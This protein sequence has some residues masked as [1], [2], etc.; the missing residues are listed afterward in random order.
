MPGAVEHVHL[1]G[2]GVRRDPVEQRSA[3]L[4]LGCAVV[5]AANG[6]EALAR[7]EEEQ[8]D[9]VFSD[10]VMPG[11]SGVELAREVRV[12]YPGL[13][14]V[15]ASGYSNEMLKGAALEFKL[16]HKP[17]SRESLAEV[18]AA[19]LEAVRRPEARAEA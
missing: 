6:H 14:V 7:L 19:A 5:S 1:A 16:L 11:L 4:D 9:I 13:P 12:L 15:L 18:L 17:Y 8:L 10:V 2:F 3:P